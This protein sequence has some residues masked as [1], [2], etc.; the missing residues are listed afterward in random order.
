MKPTPLT[1]ALLITASIPLAASADLTGPY[2]GD[3][4]TLV[5][6]HLDEAA[7]GS[8]TTN[9]GTLGGN[10]YS[11]N[12]AS[13][14]AT[15][16]LV[17]TMLGASGY[18]NGTNNFHNTEYNTTSG[19]MLGYDFNRDGSF[20]GDAGGGT[21]G[22]DAL[23]MTNL[24]IGGQLPFTLEA[25]VQ[26][27]TLAGNQEIICT[28]SSA[29]NRGFQFRISSGSLMFQY[30]LGS[31]ALSFSI[32]TSAS[33]PNA[34][35]AN[36]WYH[37]AFTFDGT[38]GTLY[39]TKLDPSVGAAN[40]LGSGKLALTNAAVAGTLCIGNR[41]RP[42]GVETFLGGID[43]VRISKVCRAANQMQFFSP[44]VS[45]TQNPVSQ[46]VDYN[47]PVTFTVG[48]SSLTALGYEWRFN[49]NAI[50]GG[51][52]TAYVIP[53]V[54]AGNAGYYDCIVTN[55]A[56]YS[57]TSSP[58]LLVVGAANFLNHRYSFN[59]NANDS[60][61]T[62]NG[63]L[64]GDAV[65]SGGALVLDGTPGTYMQL[66]G[67]L[68]TSANATALTVE[69]W[70]AF[71]VNS[72]NCYVFSFGNTNIIG[73]ITNGSQYTIFSPHNSPGQG[74]YITPSDNTFSQS[75]TA[76]T[77]LDGRNVHVA[78]VIDPPDQTLAIYTNGVLEASITNETIGLANVHDIFSYIGGSLFPADPDL[79]ATIDEL[80][81]FNGPLSPISI[82]QSNDQGPY[83]VLADGPAKFV[84]EPA[85]SST[86]LGQAATF[87]AATVGYL[88]ITYQWFENGSLIPG[89]TNA[90][91]IFVP[92]LSDNNATFL[93][94]ATNTIGV[95][96]YVTNSS[97]VTLTVFVPPTLAWADGSH[98]AADSSWNTTSADWLNSGNS[99]VPFVQTNGALFDSRGSGSPNVDIS[100]AITTYN[101]TVNASSDY[102]FYSSA[103]VGSLNGLGSLTKQNSDTLII[104]VT[105]NMAGSTLISAGKLQIGNVDSFGT[106]GGGPV[107]NNGTLSFNRS[108][109]ILAVPNAIHG[110]GT[111]SFDGSGAT[112]ISGTSDYT[113]PTHLNAGIVYL[114][115]SN[116]LGATSSGTLVANGAQL[117]ITANVDIAPEPLTLN[118]A[119][120][121]NGALRKG[122][123]GATTYYGAIS[124]GSDS[125]I[126]A[127]SGATL[128]LSNS[129]SGSAAMTF[130]GAGTIVLTTP[131]SYSQGTTLNGPVVDLNVNGALGAGAVTVSG[132]GRFVLADGLNFANALTA[133]SVNPAAGTGLIMVNDNT[134]G[135]IT[136]I[137]GPLEFDASSAS[138]GD[139]QGPTSSGYLNVLSAITGS[140]AVSSRNGFVRFSGGGNYSLFNLN[141]GTVSLGANNGLSS[142]ASLSI[143]ISG[144]ATVDLNGFNQTFSGI[145]DGATPANAEL[146]T[147]SAASASTLI[148]N[149]NTT[150]AYS[151]VI[152]GNV[153]LEIDGSGSLDL[154]GTNTYTGNTV[155]NAGILEV[156]LGTFTPNSTVSIASGAYLQIDSLTTNAVAGLILNGVSQPAGL[157]NNNNS[158]YFQG[159]G[160]LQVVPVAT[161]PTNI[162]ASVSGSTL[163]LS[164]PANHTGWRLLMQTGNLANGLST[165]PSDWTTVPGSS[166]TNQVNLAIDP[167]K[168][169]EF[170]R[171]VYP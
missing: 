91:Y 93:V 68:F 59:G 41:G 120:D 46:N 160:S 80:R 55:T 83:A 19:Y 43:E 130:A 20:T 126:G 23:G 35:V 142:S 168:P 5:L 109:T 148:L 27:T 62:A 114:T 51:T 60:V 84:T 127:D 100:Q 98:G 75:V 26:P 42:N 135:T 111:V 2:P 151:G 25:L 54:A 78:C 71:G 132:A 10:F 49:S 94:Q 141:Q 37:A 97:A 157:Y 169:A 66:P 106:L 76:N 152:G 61:G 58:A 124:L 171:M 29:A 170:F 138:G 8:V 162:V 149:L 107:T 73:G 79:N 108:D 156:A 167:A 3:T 113:G 144:G 50:A 39:W 57:A 166:S 56:G 99:L 153:G 32:P 4:N 147:N 87:S 22:A 134:N 90:S 161:N 1:L 89:A 110:S 155:I 143:A 65:V 158:A 70:A 40:V 31:Q 139:F 67:A 85:N 69:F 44:A 24:N 103:N 122:G 64:F 15:P 95:T 117:Y 77:T 140:G 92:T 96:T 63:T 105:N 164:W 118:G 81:I 131:N 34:F 48:A 121:G 52:N 21:L 123:A 13:G 112:T 6:L 145:A 82:K 88:P 102:T 163:S 28:D 137:S 11:V 119:G 30:I 72:N 45:I 104:D 154:L 116:G 165:N 17:T 136:T 133:T 159:A 146:I 125:T 150:E 129:I 74:L 16:P 86:P 128:T 38:N 115:S 33:D 12:Y 101:I 47:L 53:N 18:V 14:G 9:L 36:S 7:G